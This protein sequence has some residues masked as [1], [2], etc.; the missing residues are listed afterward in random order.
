MKVTICAI[1]SKYIHSSL[2]PWCLAGGLEKYANE[3]EYS[4]VEGT[5]NESVDDVLGRIV[6]ENSEIIGFCTYI[7]NKTYVYSLC[8][9]LKML[10]NAKIVLGGPEVSYNVQEVL[11]NSD[12][13]YILSGEGEIS[14]AQLCQGVNKNEIKGLCY[15]K[16]NEIIVSQ[17]CVLEEDPPSPY[18]KRY[19]EQLNGRIAYIETSRGCPFSCTF[20]LSGRCGGIR[21]FDLEESQ[22]RILALANSGTKTVKFIDRTFNASRSRTKRIFNFLIDNYGVAFPRDICFHFEIECELLDDETIEILKKAPIGL[23][24]FEI[25]IQSFNEKTL[26]AI[27][28][29]ANFEKLTKTVKALVALENIHIHIDLIAGLPYE[30]YD[31]FENSFNTAYNLNAHMLQFGFL[32]MLHGADIREN[33]QNHSCEY[34]KEPPY[35]VIST[36]WLPKEK[37]EI[38]H[39]CEDIFDRMYNSQRFKRTCKY[40]TEALGNPFKIFVDFA[41]FLKDKN[42]KSLDELTYQIYSYFSSKSEI[43]KDKLRDMLVIDRL[44]T[45]RMGTI[46]EFLKIHSPLTKQL[47]NELEKDEKT[48]KPKSVK[49]A[50]SLLSSMREYVYVDY[51]D[52]NSVTKEYRLYQKNI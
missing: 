44:A 9:K 41:D 48:K 45:N 28:R 35:E 3:I 19:F 49:R 46:P 15:R 38:M 5:I 25:G 17:P 23:F 26:N 43:S 11:T 20:C 29:K 12:I 52:M 24:Q 18:V 47:L 22:K 21:F 51:L 39:T 10:T 32:K 13:D 30:D 4:V 27:N 34:S 8:K 1:N 2:A 7:W 42:A 31:S 33:T 6:A 50:L 16:G 40:I 14:F 36:E 37:M